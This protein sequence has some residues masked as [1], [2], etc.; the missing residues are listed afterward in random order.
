M[1]GRWSVERIN[2]WYDALPWLVGA[3]YYPATAI[4]QID[5]W[6]ESTWDPEQI[7]KEL[8]WAADL[9]M[10]TMRVFLHDLVWEADREGLYR[11][12]DRF[13]GICGK[14]GIRPSFVFFDDCHYPEPK[15][16]PQPP[17]VRAWHNSGWVNSPARDLAVRFAEDKATPAEVARLK[18]YVQ[19]TMRRFKDDARVLYWELYNEPG[20]GT[21]LD[22]EPEHV[23][24]DNFGD[25]SSKLVHQ[26][27]VWAREVNPSQPVTSTTAGSVGKRNIAINRMNSDMHSIHNYGTP[28]EL[29][30]LIREYKKDG[31]PVIVTEWL[32]RTRGS[33]VAGSLPVMKEERAGAINWGLVSGESATIWPWES[34]KGKDVEEE[35]RKGNI[36]KPGD[37]FPEPRLWFHDL[38]HTDG[39]PYD[40]GEYEVFRTLTGK[41][42]PEPPEEKKPAGPEAD[43]SKR[44]SA[45]PSLFRWMSSAPLLVPDP[46]AMDSKV[47]FKDPTV[48]RSGGE[49]HV[50]ASAANQLGKWSIVQFR[51]RDWRDACGRKYTDFRSL[52][53]FQTMKRR[54][55]C[56]PHVF[57]FRPQRKWY[58]VFQLNGPMYS[59]SDD[60]SRPDSWT[61]PKPFFESR[62]EGISD[63]WL[64]FWVICD[65]AHAYLFFPCNDGK[66]YRSRTA[67]A[68]FPNRF[69]KPEVCLA[70]PVQDVFEANMIYRLKDSGKYLAVMEAIGV[71]T[72]G[73]SGSRPRYFRAWTA[74]R[75]DGAWSPMKGA[76]SFDRPFAGL[77]NVDFPEGVQPWTED[78]SHGELVRSSNDERMEIDGKDLCFLFQGRDP[79][80]G[81]PYV[82]QPYRLG[83]LKQVGSLR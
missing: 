70:G 35:R 17:P 2:K 21:G 61:E 34:R 15:L 77:R 50:F 43:P 41:V 69:G 36:I 54:S 83:L 31:R 46:D 48:V 71:Y 63:N 67:L 78:V 12:M 30:K 68:S 33:T 22:P 65:E 39:R 75:L 25:V 40:Q 11:R 24:S 45:A 60:L 8:G 81:A 80:A 38:F 37:P 55:F 59:T 51:F 1:P 27:W 62:P 73:E 82:F 32:A 76:D 18:G 64:D 58:L 9:G 56:A 47:S 66:L 72:G 42:K 13:L 29:R 7:D 6:Q 4:N 52:P 20:R 5:M 74:D 19:D 3:N 28:L 44:S 57:Y 49:W 26:S 53:A 10:N 79:A 16:G 14:H 23:S